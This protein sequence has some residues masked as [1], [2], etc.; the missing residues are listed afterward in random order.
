MILTADLRHT[1]VRNTVRAGIPERMAMMSSDHKTRSA[2][3][4]YDIVS[5]ADLRAAAERL[6]TPAL[7][8]SIVTDITIRGDLPSQPECMWRPADCRRARDFSGQR[9]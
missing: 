4:R 2:S 7:P 8:A 3:D 1:A 6:T 9:L 5:E